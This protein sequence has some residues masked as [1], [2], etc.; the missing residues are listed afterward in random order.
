[1]FSRGRCWPSVAITRSSDSCSIAISSVAAS[2]SRWP[3]TAVK[4][5]SQSS[6][7]G[8]TTRLCSGGPTERGGRGA[9]QGSGLA[10]VGTAARGAGPLEQLLAA[11]L[12]APGDE[13]DR[14]L[15]RPALA[16]GFDLDRAQARERAARDDLATRAVG[17]GEHHEQLELTGPS[18]AV[19]VAQL[20]REGVADVGERLLGELVAVLARELA[21]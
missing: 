11:L 17:A 10:A 14:D 3:R 16:V 8:S 20:R 18:D 7:S 19:E 13:P 9:G 6:D 15:E 2:S 12:G 5:I 1:M 21:Q 4:R